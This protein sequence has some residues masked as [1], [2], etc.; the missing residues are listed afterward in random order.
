M[1]FRLQ[2]CYSLIKKSNMK[3][4]IP[5]NIFAP[6]KL[7]A[8]EHWLAVTLFVLSLV[9]IS[10]IVVDYGFLLDDS[11]LRVVHLIYR[12]SWWCYL[13]LYI[14]QLIFGWRNIKKKSIFLI[15]VELVF[16]K[17]IS[18]INIDS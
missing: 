10:A 1:F 9:T 8:V 7:S 17:F 18:I 12:L 2:F 15:Q 13:L 14:V 6:K 5:T 4:K 16:L 11:E 3:F